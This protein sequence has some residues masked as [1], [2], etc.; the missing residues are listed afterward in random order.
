LG[1]GDAGSTKADDVEMFLFKVEDIFEITRRGLVLVPGLGNKE[2]VV[3]D[4]ILIKRPNQTIIESTILGI[5]FNEFRPILVGNGLRK[6][7][8][9]IDSEV[10][11]KES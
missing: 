3:G 9:P 8:I 1:Y 7:D 5:A 2:A 6:E 11:L 10:W 4:S